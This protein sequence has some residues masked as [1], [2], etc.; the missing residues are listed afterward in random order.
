MADDQNIA[1][2]EVSTLNNEGRRGGGRG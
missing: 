2:A 1:T